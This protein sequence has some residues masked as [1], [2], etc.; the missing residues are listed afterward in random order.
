MIM[1][2]SQK[3]NTFKVYKNYCILPNN[4]VFT[5][6][7]ALCKIGKAGTIYLAGLDGYEDDD[8]KNN[9]MSD[10]IKIINNNY[11]SNLISLF[12]TKYHIK[13]SSIYSPVHD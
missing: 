9:E 3:K 6:S 2:L 10:T 4:L 8:Y 11:K 5:Y 1:E 12:K 13:E 7:M